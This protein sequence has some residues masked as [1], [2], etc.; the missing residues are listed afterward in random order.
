[1]RGKSAYREYVFKISIHFFEFPEPYMN[2]TKPFLGI[3]LVLFLCI[4][5]LRLEFLSKWLYNNTKLPKYLY[6]TKYPFKI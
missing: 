3:A 6:S 2:I 5:Y 1:M 4:T